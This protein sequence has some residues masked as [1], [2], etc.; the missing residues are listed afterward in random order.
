MD[1]LTL[2]LRYVKKEATKGQIL[3]DSNQMKHLS[4]AVRIIETESR[5]VVAKDWGDNEGEK[6]VQWV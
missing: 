4:K 5:K 6:N 2:R 1:E 3:H